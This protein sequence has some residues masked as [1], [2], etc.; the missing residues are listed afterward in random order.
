MGDATSLIDLAAYLMDS[1]A[2]LMGWVLSLMECVAWLTDWAA[3]PI[4]KAAKAVRKVAESIGNCPASGR[5]RPFLKGKSAF[6]TRWHINCH[7]S[8]RLAKASAPWELMGQ[9]GKGTNMRHYKISM[10]FAKGRD[11]NLG[12]FTASTIKQMTDNPGYPNPAVPL[13][14]LAQAY[15]NYRTKLAASR[16]GGRLATA[17]KNAARAALVSLL[18]KQAAYVQSVAGTDLALMLSSGFHAAST[19][20]APLPLPRAMVK[21]LKSLQSTKLYLSL[22]PVRSARGYEV[23]FK[24]PTGEYIS[25]GISTSSRGIMIENLIPGVVYTIQ[26]RAI[27]GLNGYGD[28]SDPVSRMAV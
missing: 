23:R 14:E 12:S 25:R 5:S 2:W 10:K 21:S 16:D 9:P 13:A 26:A 27:G 4:S 8:A 15:T 6:R 1:I 3:F 7:D 18:R 11:A 28:W 19:N 22:E 24:T 17:A 20:R